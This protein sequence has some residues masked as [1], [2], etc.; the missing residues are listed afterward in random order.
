V[1]ERAREAAPQPIRYVDELFR[2][3]AFPAAGPPDVGFGSRSRAILDRDRYVAADQICPSLASAQSR[4]ARLVT[5]PNRGVI[6]A[7]AKADLA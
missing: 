7:L 3:D 6:H 5:V 4:A 2:G 1:E